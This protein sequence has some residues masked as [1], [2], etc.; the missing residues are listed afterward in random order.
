MR[1]EP[2]GGDI[3]GELLERAAGAR[4]FRDPADQETL[5]VLED[6]ESRP[7]DLPLSATSAL[8]Q[9]QRVLLNRAREVVDSAALE[10]G[11]PDDWRRPAVSNLQLELQVRDEHVFVPEVDL[12]HHVDVADLQDPGFHRLHDVPGQGHF[13]DDR[14]VRT[15]GNLH[16]ALPRAYRL[17]EDEVGAHRVQDPH[18][19]ERGQGQAA[20]VT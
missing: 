15:T 18:R 11:G 12:V 20:G 6:F 16:F 2:A 5:H 17:D 8:V 7:S 19:I 1:V 4:A 13:H 9:V 10:G 14:R 3:L